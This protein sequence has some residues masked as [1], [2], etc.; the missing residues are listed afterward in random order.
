MLDITHVHACGN[1]I[2]LCNAVSI[3]RWSSMHVS[4]TVLTWINCRRRAEII[5]MLLVLPSPITKLLVVRLAVARFGRTAAISS[6]SS[7]ALCP[8]RS[9]KPDT[10]SP[11]TQLHLELLGTLHT[12]CYA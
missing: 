1:A 8:F 10:S 12:L 7:A 9:L 11:D 5:W 4:I 2:I 3:K 6:S